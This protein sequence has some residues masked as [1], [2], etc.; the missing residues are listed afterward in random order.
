MTARARSARG[1]WA[2]P[3]VR[4][5]SP[6]VAVPPSSLSPIKYVSPDH[7]SQPMYVSIRPTRNRLDA[8]SAR[9]DRGRERT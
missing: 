8:P 2:N 5:S 3:S 9:A 1:T 4:R 7:N 6:Q